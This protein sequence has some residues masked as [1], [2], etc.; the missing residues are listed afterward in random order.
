MRTKV[1]CK[2]KWWYFRPIFLVQGRVLWSR[3]RA[4]VPELSSNSEQERSAWCVGKKTLKF[5]NDVKKRNDITERLR[6]GNVFSLN[7]RKGHF[8]L[9]FGKQE[10]GTTSITNNKTSARITEIGSFSTRN[11]SNGKW[12]MFRWLWIWIDLL[13]LW[14]WGCRI[15]SVGVADE[16]FAES[17]LLGKSYRPSW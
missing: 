13:V 10:N 17:N 12:K 6:E 4:R 11:S 3:A 2:Q 16:K 8:A 1:T 9:K 15:F 5:G 14:V 7:S